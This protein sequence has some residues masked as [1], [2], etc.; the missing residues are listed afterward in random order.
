MTIHMRISQTLLLIALVIA[1]TPPGKAQDLL[2]PLNEP[3]SGVALPGKFVG[4]DLA[5]PALS[6][7][8]DFY[9]SV[10]GWSYRAPSPSEDGYVLVL[11]DGRPI[12][13]MFGYDPPQGEQDGAV[14]LCLMSVSNVDDAV[15][16]AEANGGT[17]ELGPA[18][19]PRRG[20]HAL[21]RDPAGAV[22]GVLRSDSGDPPDAE[23]PIGG[24]IWVDLFARDPGSMRSF[25]TAL[26]PYE[27]ETRPV[28][29]NVV[30]LLLNAHGM[31]RAGIVPVDEEANR[32]AWVPYVRVA[33]VEATLE[34]VVQGG[35][36]AIIV[37]DK[38][39]LDG[40]VAVFVDPNGAVTGIVEWSYGAEGGS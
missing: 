37:P 7:Q 27:T 38:A 4:F 10:F 21:L 2:P 8:M 39:I 3:P 32:S 18:D 15:R 16:T 25:Y 22:F 26:A 23:V 13:G 11:N 1:W 31:P 30:R 28:T 40:K 9:R 19:V 12:G 33:D 34:R 20:R 6:E 17:L 24:F 14:W 29:D 35:G 5:S 36:F